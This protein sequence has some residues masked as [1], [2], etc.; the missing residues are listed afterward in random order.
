MV[1]EPEHDRLQRDRPR[2]APPALDR[3]LVPPD[4]GLL[5]PHLAQVPHADARR[6]SGQT[7]RPQVRHVPQFLLVV[8]GAVRLADAKFDTRTW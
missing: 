6:R 8:T 2:S 3:A 7:G 1:R 5:E 4:R